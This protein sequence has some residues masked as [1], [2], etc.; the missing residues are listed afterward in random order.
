MDSIRALQAWWNN[1]HTAPAGLTRNPDGCPPQYTPWLS[2]HYRARTRE[3]ATWTHKPG[4]VLLAYKPMPRLLNCRINTWADLETSGSA[5]P[6]TG[7]TPRFL[8]LWDA[9]ALAAACPLYL[10][11]HSYGDMIRL[12]LGQRLRAARRAVL[13]KALVAVPFTPAPGT[14]LLARD[15][16]ARAESAQAARQW[17]MEEDLIAPAVLQ[18]MRTLPHLRRPGPGAA[19]HRAVPLAKT[20]RLQHLLCLAKQRPMACDARSLHQL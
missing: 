6:R 1:A 10:K 18:P 12:G 8:T 16:T 20:W 3:R 14:R 5:T 17:C 9:G 11:T 19:P 2:S 15:A 4:N 7:W 13:P